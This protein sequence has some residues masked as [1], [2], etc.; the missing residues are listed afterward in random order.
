SFTLAT[1]APTND[2]CWPKIFHSLFVGSTCSNR[3]LRVSIPYISPSAASESLKLIRIACPLGLST[4]MVVTISFFT[5]SNTNKLLQAAPY[6]NP[7]FPRSVVS[8]TDAPFI[9]FPRKVV[10]LQ[11]GPHTTMTASFSVGLALEPPRTDDVKSNSP[12]SGIGVT[13]M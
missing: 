4:G 5:G 3:P 7:L 9:G 2:A 10:F 1:L 13:D 12:V 11:T 8:E 6:T